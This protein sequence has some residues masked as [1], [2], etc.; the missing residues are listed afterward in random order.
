MRKP[1][2]V[3]STLTLLGLA[4]TM[5]SPAQAHRSSFDATLMPV[6]A[7]AASGSVTISQVGTNTR[8]QLHAT[9][10]SVGMHMSHVH[11]VRGGQATCPTMANDTNNDGRVDIAEGL[12]AYGPVMLTLTDMSAD[13][14]TTLDYDRALKHLDNG[15]G[16]ASIGDLTHYVVVV[17]GV[18][19]DGNGQLTGSSDPAL[20][21]IAMP[22]LCAVIT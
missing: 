12:P 13:L 6:N 15:D 17:H 9:G 1:L 7:A 14:G 21:E 11:G 22:A 8:V 19:V 10:L 3:L 20:N 2:T 18:D 5:A 4:A 16:I